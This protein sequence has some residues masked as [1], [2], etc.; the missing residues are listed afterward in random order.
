MAN[1]IIYYVDC[2][3]KLFSDEFLYRERDL[4]DD[5]YVYTQCPVFNHKSNRTFIAV[6]PIDFTIQ[7]NRNRDLIVLG[8]ENYNIREFLHVD[9]L[10]SPHPVMQISFPKFLFWTEEKNVWFEY[11]DHPITS[12]NNNFIGIGG[13]FNISN[14]PR[15]TSN[16]FTVVNPTKPIV[17]KKGDPMFRVSFYPPNLDAGIILK[18]I[19]DPQKVNQILEQYNSID[20]SKT[21]WKT[22]LFSKTQIKT[23]PFKFLYDR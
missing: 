20:R 5:R 16:A 8:N 22:K 10:M 2:N 19:E 11:N 15:S 21:N 3:Q 9:D 18:K 4:L 6:S 12:L 23:C 17:I 7:I 13:W 14:W 1:V